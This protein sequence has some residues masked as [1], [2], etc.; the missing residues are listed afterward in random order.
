MAFLFV[1]PVAL[2]SYINSSLLEQFASP[3]FVSAIYVV[4]SILSIIGM[5]EMPKMLTKRGSKF[6][7]NI[8]AVVAATAMFL[9]AFSSS[10]IVVI[11]SFI[12]Y[13]ITTSLIFTNLDIFL[14]D[15]SGGGPVG[16]MR[17][18]FLTC[19]NLAWVVAQLIS[20]SIIAQSSF[21]GIY[22]LSGLFTL[23]VPVVVWLFLKKFRD[24]V[25]IK[26][27]IRKTTV[28]FLRNKNALRIYFSNLI[29]K[30]FSAWMV[31]YTPIYLH[32]HIGLP[33][34]KIGIIFSIM[35]TPYVL[36]GFPL[37]K[38]SDRLG[39][40][41]ILQVGFLIAGAAVFMLPFASEPSIWVFA[42]ILFLS[43]IG[44]GTIEV[45]SDSYF[46]KIIDEKN[47]EAVS[48]YRSA[49]SVAYIISPI[50]AIVVLSLVPEFKLIFPV[51]AVILFSG[52]LLVEKIKDVR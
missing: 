42:S 32:E 2:T 24:P 5:L 49:R 33:W 6:T 12:L 51:L 39:E 7:T 10:S 47:I 38:L 16:Q 23:L 30:F 13:F 29:F 35:L 43:R 26:I 15:L 4:A 31:I 21:I 40:K 1:I 52:I 46:F 17:G 45:M 34:D 3:V 9:M 28:F 48:F 22:I 20:G 36:V 19:I 8:F 37:G 44:A 41:R 11:A 50:V 14:E 18:V 27:S 25:Y